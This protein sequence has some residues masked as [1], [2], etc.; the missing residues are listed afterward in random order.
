MRAPYRG[1]V[2]PFLVYTALR[3]ML[4][5]TSFAIVGGL[6]RLV[7][8]PGVGAGGWFA[9]I[10]LAAVI[11]AYGSWTFLATQR[12]A[13]ARVVEGRATRAQEALERN[14]SREDVD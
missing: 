7:A 3:L 2:K 14:R 11:S 9:I 6:W 8:G 13:L 1:G 4:F 10:G 12:E 5:L